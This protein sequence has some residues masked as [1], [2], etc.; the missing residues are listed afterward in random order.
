MRYLL[1]TYIHPEPSNRVGD[2][3]LLGVLIKQRRQEVISDQEYLEPM[4]KLGR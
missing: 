2:L 1:D 4:K 3:E